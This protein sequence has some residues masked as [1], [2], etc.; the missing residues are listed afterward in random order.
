MSAARRTKADR[1]CETTLVRA[2]VAGWD[3]ETIRVMSYAAEGWAATL[4][5]VDRGNPS[6]DMRTDAKL[7]E[8]AAEVLR[9]ANGAR[10]WLEDE[11]GK[12]ETT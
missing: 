5:Q 11:R 1:E 6:P 7:L 4:M 8:A 2:L 9:R 12:Q 3:H 10:P